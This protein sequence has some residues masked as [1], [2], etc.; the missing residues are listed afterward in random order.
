MAIQV[1][2][3]WGIED[4]ADQTGFK[5]AHWRYGEFSPSGS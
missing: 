1:H 5:R 4:V 2:S 3:F